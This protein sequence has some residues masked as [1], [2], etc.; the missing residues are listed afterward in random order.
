MAHKKAR[1][2]NPGRVV[3]FEA[4]TLLDQAVSGQLLGSGFHVGVK[5][6]QV[7]QLL[8]E[9]VVFFLGQLTIAIDEVCLLYTSSAQHA[10]NPFL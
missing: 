10:A 2:G 3:C 7:A 6:V 9:L 4:I 1:P 8:D 5:V